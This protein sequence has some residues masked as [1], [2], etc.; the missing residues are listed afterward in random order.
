MSGASWAA[1][2]L[3]S[4][5]SEVGSV[6]QRVYQSLREEIVAATL[7]PSQSVAEPELARRF[8]VSRSPVREALMK[9]A[10]EGLVQVVPQVGTY[11]ARLRR[12]DIAEALFIREALE[13]AAVRLFALSAS[14]AESRRLDRNVEAQSAALRQQDLDELHRL[15]EELHR[16]I[17][18]GAG[19]PRSWKI[20]DSARGH[21]LRI[22][23]LMA[24]DVTVR[25]NSVE[26]HIEIV[27]ALS[28]HD[29]DAA[30]AAMRAHA[31]FNAQQLESLCRKHIEYFEDAGAEEFN[32]IGSDRVR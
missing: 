1:K 29:P 6:R 32:F 24:P 9:L 14:A 15:D 13:C 10:E 30:E 8:G 22:R 28:T 17:M 31:R 18:E 27:R 19:Q 12:S 7:K 23:N 25:T 26:Q 3:S 11:V 20:V 2:A 5:S 21:F 16:L 4:S